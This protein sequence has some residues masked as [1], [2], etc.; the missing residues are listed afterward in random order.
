MD[1]AEL[2]LMKQEII[3]RTVAQQEAKLETYKILKEKGLPIPPDLQ[4][5]FKQ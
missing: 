5:E 3:K 2:E 4:N 1:D